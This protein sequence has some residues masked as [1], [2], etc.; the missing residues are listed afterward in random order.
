M[1]SETMIPISTIVP[2]AIAMPD[3]A[4]TLASTPAYFIAM[5]HI[6]TASGIAIARQINPSIAKVKHNPPNK[7]LA[8]DATPMHMP[9]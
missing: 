6:S 4:T 5:K 7:K 8:T 2:I 1:F 3:S 9:N